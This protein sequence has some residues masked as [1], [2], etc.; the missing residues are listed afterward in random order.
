METL[1]GWYGYDIHIPWSKIRTSWNPL[2]PFSMAGGLSFRASVITQRRRR[3]MR[4]DGFCHE[5]GRVV[6]LQHDIRQTNQHT[7]AS[8]M[9]TGFNNTR[10][11]E[12]ITWT[13]HCIAASL[14]SCLGLIRI[15]KTI[16]C[17]SLHHFRDLL[18]D[19]HSRK[20][21]LF[22]R[23]WGGCWTSRFQNLAHLT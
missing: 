7:E 11:P 13:W 18:A 9:W 20:S 10:R 21:A 14:K 19:S 15:F 6:C 23:I 8:E 16:L 22:N 2:K 12:M 3:S 5:R 1:P 17:S 4:E